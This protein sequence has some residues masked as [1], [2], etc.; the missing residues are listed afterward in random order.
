M[1][2][3]IRGFILTFGGGIWNK[4]GRC[5]IRWRHLVF[6][7][8]AMSQEASNPNFYTGEFRHGVDPKK[9]ITIPAA[10]KDKGEK[11]SATLYLRVNTKGTCLLALPRA[12]F[13][14][15]MAQI[16]LTPDPV[17]RENLARAFASACFPCTVDSQRR[18]VLPTDMCTRIGVSDE[19]VLVGVSDRF[20]IW[21]PAARVIPAE[22]AQQQ[23]D[24]LG[25]LLGL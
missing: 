24:D 5:G 7:F 14:S 2:T 19:V 25:A 12:A 13:E 9:R 18:M 11:E 21:N 23:E 8:F 15:A 1:E 4:V 16:R 17:R 6:L 22:V 3:L 20:E 10:W